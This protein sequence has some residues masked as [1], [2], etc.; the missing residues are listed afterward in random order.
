MRILLAILFSFSVV[1]FAHEKNHRQHATHVHGKGFISL[2]FDETKGQL[3]FKSASM[4]ILGFEHKAKSAKDKKKLE[5]VN[6]DFQDNM[7]NY[8]QFDP[9]SE[10][11][12]EKKSIGMELEPSSKSGD[13]GHSD[14][15]AKFEIN[16]SRP[17]KGTNLTLDFSSFK[18]LTDVDVVILIDELQLKSELKSKKVTIE[19]K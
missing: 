5:E 7:T 12:F 6:L 15:I 4:A 14:Y 9:K 13:S 2:A 1:A 8:V 19:L 10:C 11:V 17:L 16:C 18:K 3:E